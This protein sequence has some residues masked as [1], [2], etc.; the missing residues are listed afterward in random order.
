MTAR[1]NWSGSRL[2]PV[3]SRYALTTRSRRALTRRTFLPAL[4]TRALIC[5][6]PCAPSPASAVRALGMYARVC[7]GQLDVLM[8]GAHVAGSPTEL[9]VHSTKPAVEQMSVSGTGIAKAIAGSEAQLFVRIADRFGNKF[10]EGKQSFPYSFGLILNPTDRAIN[11]KNDKKNK[12]VK[13]NEPTSKKQIT[14]QPQDEK[15]AASV[16][17]KGVHMHMHAHACTCMHMHI[18]AHAHAHAYAH[19]HA[20]A[21]ATYMLYAHA[22]AHATYMLYAHAHAHAHAHMHVMHVRGA[23]APPLSKLFQISL[24]R[25]LPELCVCRVVGHTPLVAYDSRLGTQARSRG[26]CLRSGTLPRRL[27]RW[28]CTCGRRAPVTVRIANHCRG[29]RSPWS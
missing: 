24:E 1:T 2:V 21:H 22:H 27:A 23:P 4:T 8:D 25:K 20:H 9:I 17:F 26:T 10:E 7:G 19:A 15:K 29:R 6:P 3:S 14:G 12:Q 5:V 18:H 16:P 28:T 13:G 11:D